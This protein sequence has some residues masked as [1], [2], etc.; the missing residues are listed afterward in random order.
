M[1]MQIIKPKDLWHFSNVLNVKHHCHQCQFTR[2]QDNIIYV[3]IY[4]CVESFFLG[5]AQQTEAF[6]RLR[7][8]HK[9]LV[10]GIVPLSN[11]VKLMH[12]RSFAMFVIFNERI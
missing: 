4:V 11:V 10:E 5:S 8:A 3:P 12:N 7:V 6:V 1:L 9:N 2:S